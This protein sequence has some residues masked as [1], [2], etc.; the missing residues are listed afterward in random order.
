MMFDAL[1]CSKVGTRLSEVFFTCNALMQK[2]KNRVSGI[3]P[4]MVAVAVK[5][6]CTEGGYNND[7]QFISIYA[8]PNKANVKFRKS[9]GCSI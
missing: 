1:R 4:H 2:D 6:F 3:I 9:W 8:T 7:F 5:Y